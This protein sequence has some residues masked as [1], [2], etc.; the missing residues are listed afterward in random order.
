MIC[1][2]GDVVLVPFPFVDLPITRRR[3]AVMISGRTFNEA[4]HQS[5]LAMITTAA[6]S[7][8]ASD[9]PLTDL[10]A[11]GLVAPCVVRLKLFTLENRLLERRLGVLGLADRAAVRQ[12][13]LSGIDL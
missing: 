1:D 7:S 5:V 9:T 8:W 3:P 11:A 4:E 10:A 12:A 2:A 6:A 13:V